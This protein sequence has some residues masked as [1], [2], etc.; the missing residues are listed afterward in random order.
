MEATLTEAKDL[1]G[2]AES[3][4][5]RTGAAF[6][7]EALATFP[8]SLSAEIG[9]RARFSD[10]VLVPLPAE[11]PQPRGVRRVLEA[12]LFEAHVPVLVLPP[13]TEAEAPTR[14]VVVGWNDRDAALSA[15][16]E[17]MPLLAAAELVEIVLVDPSA[18]TSEGF[19]PGTRLA[20]YLA[21]HGARVEIV[22]LAKTLPRVSEVFSRRVRDTE[23]T[24]MVMGAYSHSRLREAAIW[25]TTRELL[26]SATVPLFLSR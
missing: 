6:A 15:V 8:E 9:A 22:E 17:A 21:H 3:E 16:R 13:A 18:A 11:A 14:R 10:L 23:A 26:E 20:E 24:L 2:F 4:L 5:R 19:D 12:A 7:V 1:K 25:G